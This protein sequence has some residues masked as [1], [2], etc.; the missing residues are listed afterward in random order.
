MYVCREFILCYLALNFI[1]LIN[2]CTH[3]SNLS[4]LECNFVNMFN[5]LCHLQL[6]H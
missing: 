6:L 2:Y 1:K 3:K 4:F 5:I